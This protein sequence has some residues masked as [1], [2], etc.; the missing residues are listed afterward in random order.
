M[1]GQL[2]PFDKAFAALISDL[3]ERKMLDSTLIMVSTEF[4]RTPKVNK[5]KARPLAEGVQHCPGRR[6]DQAR[7]HPWL[8]RCDRASPT[9]IR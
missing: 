8:I 2:P 3:E 9:A 6:R 5:T 4:G 7:K 1:Q